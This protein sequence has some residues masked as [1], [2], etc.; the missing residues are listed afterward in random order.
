[1]R[2]ALDRAAFLSSPITGAALVLRR[3][4]EDEIWAERYA[5]SVPVLTVSVAGS[6]SGEAPPEH[7]VSRPAP[8]APAERVARALEEAVVAAAAGGGE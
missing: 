8:R 3:I 5:L 7:P 2:A 4:E 1:V 6:G